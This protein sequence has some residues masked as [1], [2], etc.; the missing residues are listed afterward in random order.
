MTLRELAEQAGLDNHGYERMIIASLKGKYFNLF[1][2]NMD[3]DEII[4]FV[5]L[6]IKEIEKKLEDKD[7][8]I[9]ELKVHFDNLD[10]EY[11]D[12]LHRHIDTL[13]SYLNELY[14]QMLYASPDC[15]KSSLIKRTNPNNNAG[16]IYL[17]K[18]NTG[19]YKIG[20]T[21]DIDRR[22]GTLKTGNISYRTIA[23]V[24][25]PN[26]AKEETALH[27]YF[28][29]KNVGGEWFMLNDDD[30]DMLVSVF[31]FSFHVEENQA[32]EQENV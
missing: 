5:N 13:N 10:K 12:S 24:F 21:V 25:V 2:P 27:H 23:S 6:Y 32:K 17:A 7:E 31:G 8:A 22:E 11:I 20:R 16:F 18:D 19:L 14:R 1:S 9:E 26:A 15:G 4:H 29:E 30:L 3:K 28:K